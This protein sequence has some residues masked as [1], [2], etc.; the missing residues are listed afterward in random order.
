MKKYIILLALFTLLCS[1]FAAVKPFTFTCRTAVIRYDQIYYEYRSHT[2]NFTIEVISDSYGYK[3]EQNYRR[4]P[5]ILAYPGEYY[6]VRIHNPMPVRVAVNLMID[7]LN[8]IDGQPCEPSSGRMWLM[9]PNSYIT[10]SGWQVDSYS[11]RRFY[12][13]NVSDSYA[14]W[15]SYQLDRDLT[16]KCGQISAAFFWKKSD[17]EDYF[18]RQPI[19]E[20]PIYRRHHH[21]RPGIYDEQA[22]AAPSSPFTGERRLY[23][24]EQNSA[25]TGM[26]ERQ[27]HSVRGVQFSYDTGMYEEREVVKIF[28]DFRS[29]K[30]ERPY[31]YKPRR[32]YDEDNERFAPEK[33]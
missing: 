25:G 33:P 23:E 8:S 18:L 2:Y 28:Y 6:S 22:K 32:Y 26:G 11:L 3:S 24:E 1:T 29:P 10:I 31:P 7:G 5:F 9:E 20:G 30:Y 12:F 13:T 15:R 21:H 17:M 4:H 27:G 16:V 14:E 19:Y